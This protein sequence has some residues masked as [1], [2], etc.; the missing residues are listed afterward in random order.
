M[1]ELP[2]P[3]AHTGLI[4]G[5]RR[6]VQDDAA[7]APSPCSTPTSRRTP[8]PRARGVIALKEENCTVCMLCARQCPDWCIYIEGHKEQRPPRREGGRA[9][10]RV[11]VLDRFDID[12]ALCMYCGI[13]VEVCPFDAL[14]WSPEF[15]YSEFQIAELLHD[16]VKSGR[17]DGRRCPNPSRSRSGPKSKG[18]EVGTAR[19][20]QQVAFGSS[21][22]PWS[23][24]RSAWSAPSNIVHAAL[25][26]VVVLAGAAAQYILLAAEFVAWVQVL[27]YIGAVVV[28]FL[29]GI[30]LTRAPIAATTRDARQRPAMAARSSVSLFVLGVLD[31]AAGQRVRRQEDPLQQRAR[32][33]RAHQPRRRRA[34][35]AV[36]VV[37]VRGRVRAPA[38]RARRRRRAGPEGLRCCSTSSSSWRLPLL[39]R[40][41][42]RPGPSQRRAG[43]HERRADA[44]RRQHQPGRVRRLRPRT[45]PARSS[46]CS[47][48]P[49]RPPRSA[50]AWPS[51]C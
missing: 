24:P 27:I 49:S 46:P 14:F 17:V 36:Y 34:S 10:R 19:G 15:E 1:P 7:A 38:R 9:P 13:C 16:K 4:G 11:N 21:R 44:Q 51:S 40:D 23:S 50:S 41:L 22:S 32:R 47:S 8:A 25:F 29:F 33:P 18:K 28:L 35:S 12:Y 30:M 3:K 31:R 2:K 39:H 37:P 26:L 20:S 42:R 48:S 5:P 43:A 6:D 45:S